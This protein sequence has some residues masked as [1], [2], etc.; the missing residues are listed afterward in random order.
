VPA[1]PFDVLPEAGLTLV[2]LG[3]AGLALAAFRRRDV[4][5]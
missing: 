2:A 4:P 3:L 1:E 5:A